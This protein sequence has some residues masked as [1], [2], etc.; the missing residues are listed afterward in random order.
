MSFRKGPPTVK[1][2]LP[3]AASPSAGGVKVPEVGP[4]VEFTLELE[5]EDTAP[6]RARETVRGREKVR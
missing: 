2:M 1:A 4:M 6:D 5:S 3:I